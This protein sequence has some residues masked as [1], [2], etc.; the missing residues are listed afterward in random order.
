MAPFGTTSSLTRAVIIVITVNENTPTR[1][2]F[3]LIGNC[4]SHTIIIGIDITI[5]LISKM[6]GPS[7]RRY[8]ILKQSVNR[9]NEVPT[10]NAV[11]CSFFAFAEEQYATY[12]S[13]C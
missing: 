13:A 12:V 10:L 11:D 4:R 5:C 9:S 8:D 1:T 3:F 7:G 6:I 2:S